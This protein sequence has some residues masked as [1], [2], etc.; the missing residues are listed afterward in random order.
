MT[1]NNL[2]RSQVNDIQQEMLPKPHFK[3]AEL[4]V[5]YRLYSRMKNNGMSQGDIRKHFKETFGIGMTA[6]Y[7]RLRKLGIKYMLL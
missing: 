3:E 6:F 7:T 4:E 5:F 2:W 1:G